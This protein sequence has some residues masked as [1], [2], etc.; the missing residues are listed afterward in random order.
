MNRRCFAGEA[1]E[2]SEKSVGRI[3]ETG[4]GKLRKVLFDGRSIKNGLSAVT[5]TAALAS[6]CSTTSSS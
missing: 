3:G 4:E 6:G 2:D 5:G 1:A